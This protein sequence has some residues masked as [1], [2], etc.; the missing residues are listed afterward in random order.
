MLILHFFAHPH[1][2][3]PNV[4]TV[5]STCVYK[6]SL[7]YSDSSDRCPSGQYSF[8]NLICS[9]SCFFLM[10]A[11][12]RSVASSVIPRY[13]AVLAGGIL[14]PL[15]RID[16]GSIFWFVKLIYV[17]LV[18]LSLLRYL[19]VQVAISSHR[20]YSFV[21]DSSSVFPVAIIVASSANVAI[22]QFNVSGK[23]LI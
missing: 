20:H 19:R 13:I 22:V 1:S 9:S 4:H 17:D 18:S 3:T 11:F 21:V 6:S 5:R 10:C 12:H 16:R 23:S 8:Q 14:T 7:L 2:W 15:R